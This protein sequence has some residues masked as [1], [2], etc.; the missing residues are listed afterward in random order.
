MTVWS[1]KICLYL[2]FI[3][4]KKKK[5]VM[6][7]GDLFGISSYLSTPKELKWWPVSKIF[8]MIHSKVEVQIHDTI[9]A[10]FQVF[11]PRKLENPDTP[12]L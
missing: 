5:Y 4:K 10:K 12:P 8:F 6:R 9:N 2:Y 11:R 1:Q 3:V 7:F